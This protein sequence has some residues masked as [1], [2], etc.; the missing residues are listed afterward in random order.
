[1]HPL[2][3][4]SPAPL[5]T[6]PD[7]LHPISTTPTPWDPTDDTDTPVPAVQG[8]R[9]SVSIRDPPPAFEPYTRR[10]TVAPA[11]DD[12]DPP[13]GIW[14]D[15]QRPSISSPTRHGSIW[16]DPPPTPK[17][18]PSRRASVSFTNPSLPVP[19]TRIDLP[20]KP[21]APTWA[22]L[23]LRHVK[24]VDLAVGK[25]QREWK[26]A[27]YHARYIRTLLAVKSIQ[28]VYRVR[29]YYLSSIAYLKT[30][31]QPSLTPLYIRQ[32]KSLSGRVDYAFCE[33]LPGGYTFP[34]PDTDIVDLAPTRHAWRTYVTHT[35]TPSARI[36]PC[37]A[38]VVDLWTSYDL[39]STAAP[40]KYI[41]HKPSD[42]SG[43]WKGFGGLDRTTRLTTVYGRG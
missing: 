1:M 26:R 12:A 34:T 23:G 3:D 28:R 32:L 7:P 41:S 8:H 15:T 24:L 16:D 21:S 5:S 31:T 36:P 2:T 25:I 18:G 4:T 20:F 39:I 19:T 43:V 22:Q 6:T 33:V 38:D 10:N 40:R 17:R 37:P 14:T 27:V 42:S 35:H 30:T 13:R 9:A 11:P 29:S